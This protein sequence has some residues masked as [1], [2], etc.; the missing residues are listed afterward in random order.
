MEDYVKGVNVSSPNTPGLRS[1]QGRQELEK[2]IDKVQENKYYY[3]LMYIKEF[4]E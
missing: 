3:I 1:L 2:L 4:V